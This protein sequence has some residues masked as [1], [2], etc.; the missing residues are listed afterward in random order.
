MCYKTGQVY[1]LLTQMAWEAWQAEWKACPQVAAVRPA[2][3]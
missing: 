1:L 2:Q 3:A